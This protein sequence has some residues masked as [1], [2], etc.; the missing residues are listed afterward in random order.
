MPAE[1]EPHEATWL[2]WPHNRQT[3]P[4]G[5]AIA[6]QAMAQ[7]VRLLAHAERVHINVLNADHEQHVR[8][9]LDDMAP[10]DALSFHRIP[11]NDAW[12]RDHGAI[13]VRRCA[14]PTSLVALDFVYN[15]WG[16]KYPPFDLDRDVAR[17]MALELGMHRQAESFVLEGGSIDVNGAGALLTTSQCLLN[18]NRNPE[19]D[20]AG[21]EARLK[22]CLGVESIIWLGDGIAG[23]DTDGHVDDIT[24]F[25]SSET[26]VT[27]IETN[28]RDPNFAALRRNRELLEQTS[29]AGGK[30]LTVVELPMPEPI[31]EGPQRLPASYANFY[32]GNEVVLM[33]AFA[34][35]Q[36][37]VAAA[38]LEQCFPDRQIAPIDCRGLVEGLGALHCLTQQ[39]PLVMS[40]QRP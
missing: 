16:G 17:L 38:V 15:A 2:S 40:R 3:W 6:E 14:E 22:R 36:D 25:V 7:V 35:R 31:Y 4:R 23:D 9:L 20:Q 8:S 28:R 39:V 5:L 24:R 10:R 18:P 34:C 11:T 12:I 37:A 32:I 1:W 21:I 33:P 30:R 29:L 26:V 13:F 19:L 27:A